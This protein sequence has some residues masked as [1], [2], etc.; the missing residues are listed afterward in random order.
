MSGAICF[1][2]TRIPV[3]ML[4]DNVRAGVPLSEFMDNYPD[5]TT[6]QIQA[7]LDWEDQQAREALGLELVA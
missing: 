1:V 2:G 7:V 3:V 6:A 4:L 5:L